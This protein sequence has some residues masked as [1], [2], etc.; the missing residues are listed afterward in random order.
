MEYGFDSRPGHQQNQ[1]VMR[2]KA[3]HAGHH[4]GFCR[5]FAA[6]VAIPVSLN[7]RRH[8]MATIRKRGPYQFQAEVRRKGYPTQTHTFETRAEARD[9][10]SNIESAMVRGVFV[11]RT[12]AEKTTLREALVR[13]RDEVT[14]HKR[15]AKRESV[16]IEAWLKHTLASRSLANLRGT[17]F[18]RYR[19]ERVKVVGGN[20]VRLELAVISHCFTIAKKEWDIPVSNPIKHIRGPKLPPGR[21]RRLEINEKDLLLTACGK[22]KNGTWLAAVV[23]LAIESGMRESELASIEWRQMDLPRQVVRL[24]KTKNGDKRPVPLSDRA[25]E[26]LKGLPQD[27]HGRV[28][29][30]FSSGEAISRAFGRVRN[31]AVIKD[32]RFHDLRHEAAS[33]LAPHMTVQTLAKIMGWRTLQMAMRYYN[34]TEEQL[35][36]AVRNASR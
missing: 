16:R 28:F 35:V 34:P 12:E 30:V 27:I 13:Y 26:I 2:T 21:E 20:T 4:S 14:A 25:V 33:R 24:E 8:T 23:E 7:Y 32:L 9:W 31:A 22:V 5:I 19:D 3:V 10:S 18:A 29:P 36:A 6:L 1:Y 15:S 11:D 17:D